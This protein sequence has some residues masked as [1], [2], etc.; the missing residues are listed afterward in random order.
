MGHLHHTRETWYNQSAYHLG[1]SQICVLIGTLAKL[2]LIWD[3]CKFEPNSGLCKFASHLGH[4]GPIWDTCKTGIPFGN[5]HP[6]Q[7][8]CRFDSHQRHF[9]PIREIHKPAP[10]RDI[11]KLASHSGHLQICI[12]FGTLQTYD[13]LVTFAN[14]CPIRDFANSRPIHNIDK[15]MSHSGHLQTCVPFGTMGGDT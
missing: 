4:L 8:I 9:N 10:I 6:I 14:T 15:L 11:H 7:G 12:P 3:T 1:Q 13:S 5:L 2:H